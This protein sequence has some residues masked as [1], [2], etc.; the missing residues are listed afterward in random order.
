MALIRRMTTSFVLSKSMD[1]LQ[2]RMKQVYQ[3]LEAWVCFASSP[4]GMLT[5]TATS[6]QCRRKCR[7]CTA[8]AGLGLS[9]PHCPS[10][11][12]RLEQHIDD[13]HIG[14]AVVER[15]ARLA[16]EQD[17]VRHVLHLTKVEFLTL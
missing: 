17:R 5:C 6:T 12:C 11:T 2:N 15:N 9:H 16:S 3:K 1:S 13:S 7:N 8:G 10:R 4:T 14:A